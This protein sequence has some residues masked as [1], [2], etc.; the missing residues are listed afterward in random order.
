MKKF[1]MMLC[2]ALAACVLAAGCADVKKAAVK[3]AADAVKKT[4]D[5]K[6][7]EVAVT[8]IT[9]APEGA[10]FSVEIPKTHEKVEVESHD[11]PTDAGVL[12]MSTHVAATDDMAFF[13]AVTPF[14]L[15]DK[16]SPEDVKKSLEEGARNMTQGGPIASLEH[17]K[18]IGLDAVEIHYTLNMQGQ[19]AHGRSIVTMKDSKLYQLQFLAPDA[20]KIDSEQA[21][22]FFDTFKFTDA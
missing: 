2:V 6:N 7:Q 4:Q 20:S 15:G 13:V 12:K 21:R 9:Y 10:G 1:Y 16:L 5:A 22:K 3:G 18:Y 11:M 14:P 8:Y 19:Q 17:K